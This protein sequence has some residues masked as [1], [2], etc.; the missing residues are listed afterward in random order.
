MVTCFMGTHCQGTKYDLQCK[1]MAFLPY[2]VNEGPDQPVH[3]LIHCHQTESTD[4]EEYI[5]QDR[6]GPDQT[7]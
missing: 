2:A 1:N 3:S 5:D 4:S 7:V 6:E